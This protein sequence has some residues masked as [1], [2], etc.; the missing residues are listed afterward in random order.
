MNAAERE[1]AVFFHT[2]KRLPLEIDHGEGVY[3]FTKD[4]KRYLD[5]FGGLAVNALG[6]G[7]SDLLEAIQD[8]SRRYIHLSNYYLQEPQLRLAEALV[9][10][11]GF[12]RVF[13]SNSGTE[14]IEGAL[15]IARKWGTPRGKTDLVSF[16]NAFHG[17]TFGALS[18]MDRP[19]YR[20]GYGPFLP[21]CCVAAF[22]DV[23]QLH[24][25]ISRKT[26]A[27]VLE[28]I[29]GEGGIH[30]VSEPFVAALNALKRQ[31]GFL[32]IADE[33]QSG[34]GRTGKMFGFQYFNISPDIV[35]VAKPI[36][37]GLPLGAILGSE[38]VAS[39]LEPGVHGT[40][41]GGNPVACAAGSVVLR[42]VTD[43]GLLRNAEQMGSILRSGLDTLHEEFPHLVKEVR[44]FGLMQGMELTR[45]GEGVV[46][47]LRERGILLNCTGKTVLRFLPPLTITENHI[48]E[49]I[50]HLREI[51]RSLK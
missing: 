46:A 39:V 3:L 51:F 4:G 11:S 33:I 5:M 42:K 14:A 27:V 23:D 19:N 17:R 32:L 31:F 20:E 48:T 1:S 24:H 36:G 50:T 41:F 12:S 18:I 7:D 9:K 25:A 34:I 21:N 47:S 8:Q 13:F 16:S 28:F 35:T 2:Y 43:G 40:T 44:G 45:E 22:N 26:T 49:T 29:Q 37:G 30:P 10:H 15:K 6:Y 38:H